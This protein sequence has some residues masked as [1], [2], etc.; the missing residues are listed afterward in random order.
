[1]SGLDP[2]EAQFPAIELGISEARA[3]GQDVKTDDGYAY[4]EKRADSE[5]SEEDDGLGPAPTDEELATL[6]RVRGPINVATF[7]IGFI[8]LAERFSYYGCTVVV[9]LAHRATDPRKEKFR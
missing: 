2:T 5:I 6:R 1:M 8:E 3:K 9:S 4:E 7:L